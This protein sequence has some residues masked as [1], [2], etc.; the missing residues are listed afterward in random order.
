MIQFNHVTVQYQQGHPVLSNMNMNIKE[1][2]FG[3]LGPNGAG[4]TTFIRLLATL[5]RPSSGQVLI[6]GM[7]VHQHTALIRKSIGFMPQ[8]FQ[9]QDSMTGRELLN[10]VAMA[11]GIQDPIQ[12]KKQ[13]ELKLEE[14]GL[15]ERAEHRIKTYSNG[16]KQ[17]LGIAQALVGDPTV[18]IVD[19]PTSGLDPDE[20]AHFRSLFN[21]YGKHGTVI[22]STHIVADIEYCCD[23]LAVLNNGTICYQG[24]TA[25]LAEHAQGRVWQALLSDEQFVLLRTERLVS[26]KKQEGGVMCR[27]ISEQS[28]INGAQLIEPSIED[29]YLALIGGWQHD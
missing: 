10:F 25:E 15:T 11:K 12:R 13:I 7:D 2:V 4:K 26:A 16:M 22:L 23:H 14:V 3:L 6:E 9:A 21:R 28:P 20:R 1:G 8:S 17:R 29:G 19:E 27:I 5:I 24:R 18:L